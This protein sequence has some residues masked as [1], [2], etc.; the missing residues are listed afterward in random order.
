M[1]AIYGSQTV[2][3]LV[4]GVSLVSIQRNGSHTRK[5]FRAFQPYFIPERIAPIAS[6]LLPS[7]VENRIRNM[8][9]SLKP[10]VGVLD[11]KS[12]VKLFLGYKKLPSSPGGKRELFNRASLTVR[13]SLEVGES[14]VRG[15]AGR[16]RPLAEQ[17]EFRGMDSAWHRSLWMVATSAGRP[18]VE[19]LESLWEGRNLIDPI[20]VLQQWAVART[21]RNDP[22]WIENN[23]GSIESF[24]IEWAMYRDPSREKPKAIYGWFGTDRRTGCMALKLPSY[25]VTRLKIAGEFMQRRT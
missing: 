5:L 13:K 21:G 9:Y 16:D 10:Q 18:D 11:P 12:F 6:I 4:R 8:N 7:E 24:L 1:T 2:I 20:A 3:R 15:W 22:H 19:A 23:R 25:A 17:L 14:T